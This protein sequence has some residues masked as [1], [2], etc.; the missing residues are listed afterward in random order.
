MENRAHALTAGLFVILLS[1][2]IAVATMWFSGGTAT[3]DKY[4]LVSEFPVNGLNPQAVVRYRGVSIGKVESIR[5]DPKT[6]HLIL[7]RIAVDPDLELTKNVYAQLGYQGLTG[8]AFVQLNDDGKQAERLQ[9]DSDNP[10]QI[11]FRPSALDS[12][13]ESGQL[14][15]SNAN[16]LMER[17]NLLLS[18]QNQTRFSHILENT[19]G[20]TGRLRGAVSQLEPGLKSLPGLAADASSV[21]KHTDQLIID[22]NQITAKINRQGGPVDSLSH[23]AGELTDTM[24]KL[25]EATEGI[26]RNSRSVDRVL[27]QLEEQPRSLLFGRSPPPPGPGEDGFVSPQAS[28]QGISK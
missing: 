7:I 24:H 25:R 27:L 26:A 10:A 8:L 13:A 1:A 3:R 22:L 9:T 11:P 16:G 21:L 6:P 5:L 14:L 4:L 18:D 23:T 2:A 12:I 19:E 17:L 20:L 15:L 28:P